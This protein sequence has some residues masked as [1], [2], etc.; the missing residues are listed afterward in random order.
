MRYFLD[1]EFNG[2]GGQLISLALVPEDADAAPFYAAL[3]CRDPEP[4]AAEHVIPVLRTEP[5]ERGA[6]TQKLADYLRC[7][8]NPLVVADW[9]EDIAHLA[10][11]M[12][13]GPGSRLATPTLVFEL[14]DLPLFDAKTQS[15]VPHNACHDA[16][17][18]RDYVL[19]TDH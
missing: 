15:A 13:T 11:L 17:A 3:P 7:D 10:L 19:K 5:I 12:V 2:F 8:A 1:A 18:L 4:W 14:R 16:M 6:M 9:P